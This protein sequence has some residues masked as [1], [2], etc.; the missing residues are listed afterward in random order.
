M[1]RL[2][3][4]STTGPGPGPDAGGAAG[5][6][7]EV[8]LA[9]AAHPDDIEFLM[10]GT[11]A[12]LRKAG[13]SVHYLNLSTGNCG[14]AHVPASRLRVV[15]RREAQAAAK[16]LGA[17]W[18]APMADDLEIFYT[19]ALLRRLAAVMRRVRPKVVLTHALAD[20][21][22]D[23][24]NTARLAVTAAFARGMPNYR[25]VPRVSAWSGEV[26]V[27]HALPHGLQDPLGRSVQPGAW[28]DIGSVLEVKR[29]ALACHGSQGSWLETSQGMQSYVAS[30]IDLARAAGRQSGV[31][32][33]A[34]GWTRHSTLG[35]CGAEVD[36]L[37]TVL[38]NTGT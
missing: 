34:E 4:R 30:M 5:D 18:H 22:E 15:R 11:L 21:M 27:Y 28:V 10:A 25:T 1:R 24:V 9:V 38:E 19:D 31:F 3:S 20:Y 7:R 36:P 26:T 33:Y 37:A 12:L 29:Q 23:H 17:T 14:S 35:F 2:S 6:A 13:W 32:E 16:V 8:V